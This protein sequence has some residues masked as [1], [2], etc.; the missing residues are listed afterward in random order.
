MELDL[1]FKF[2][3]IMTISIKIIIIVVAVAAVMVKLNCHF[4]KMRFKE[5]CLPFISD[6]IC[7]FKWVYL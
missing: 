1:S 4:L 7:L 2:V 6:L 3:I 5:A